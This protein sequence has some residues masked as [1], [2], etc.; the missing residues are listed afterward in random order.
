MSPTLSLPS[1]IEPARKW[2]VIGDTENEG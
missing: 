2:T 1:P